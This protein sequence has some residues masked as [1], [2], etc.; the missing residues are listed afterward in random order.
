LAGM[1]HESAA[2]AGRQLRY[3]LGRI[4]RGVELSWNQYASCAALTCLEQSAGFAMRSV[5]RSADRKAGNGDLVFAI[6]AARGDVPQPWVNPFSA[7]GP[8]GALILRARGMH[9]LFEV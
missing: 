3:A 9:K 1:M 6:P 7:L 2:R 8:V 4:T 5:L